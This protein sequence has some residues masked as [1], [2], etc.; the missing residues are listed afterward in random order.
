[1]ADI[2]EEIEELDEDQHA[3][4]V[5]LKIA[6]GLI[7][8]RY[9]VCPLCLTFSMAAVVE[10]AEERGLVHHWGEEGE[11]DPAEK[12]RSPEEREQQDDRAERLSALLA[13]FDAGTKH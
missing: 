6:T 11:G 1:M 5:A 3:A 2:D 12:D 13:A 8:R 4:L 7:A 9:Q 10:Q